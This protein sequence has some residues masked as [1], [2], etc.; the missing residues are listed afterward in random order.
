M[1]RIF[2]YALILFCTSVNGQMNLMDLNENELKRQ[3]NKYRIAADVESNEPADSKEIKKYT[4]ENEEKKPYPILAFGSNL[5]TGNEAIGF[6]P[7]IIA[8]TPVTKGVFGMDA[9]I[10]VTQVDDQNF[11]VS[12]TGQTLFISEISNYS[13]NLRAIVGIPNIA[14]CKKEKDKIEPRVG[15]NATLFVRGNSLFNLDSTTFKSNKN[16]IFTIGGNIGV[17]CILIKE[18]ISMFCDFNYLGITNNRKVYH[19]YFPAGAKKDFWY[20]RPGFRFKAL[21][22]KDEFKGLVFDVSTIFLSKNMKTITGSDNTLIPIIKIGYTK[23]IEW[24][25]KMERKNSTKYRAEWLS[26]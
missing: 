20:F 18:H 8:S 9:W 24:R 10:Q 16:D 6:R 15:F 26:L 17:E 4:T 23:K 7:T 19:D 12:R 13:A 25:R 11:D 14:E 2:F 3:E 22:G 21:E 5:A 1:K